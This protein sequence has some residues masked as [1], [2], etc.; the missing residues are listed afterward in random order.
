MGLVCAQQESTSGPIYVTSLSETG[1]RCSPADPDLDRHLF[2]RFRDWRQTKPFPEKLVTLQGLS[3]WEFSLTGFTPEAETAF[4]AAADIWAS[5]LSSP[6]TI[7]VDAE[8]VDLGDLGALGLGGPTLLFREF[9]GGVPQTFYAEAL[10]DALAGADLDPGNSDI[11]VSINSGFTGWYLGTDGNPPPDQFDLLS[12]VL[13]ELG[14]GLG[15]VDSFDVNTSGAG[16][17]GLDGRPLIYDHFVEDTSGRNLIDTA[18]YPNS[19]TT[20]GAAL[21]SIVLFN[22]AN[23]SGAVL[24][25]PSSFSGSSIVHLDDE[26]YPH[27]NPDA[28]MNPFLGNGQARH[29]LGPI[30]QGIFQDMG[31]AW[32]N[33]T[34]N[35]APFADAGPSQ[36]VDEGETV[37]LDSVG[38][39]DPDGDTLSVFWSQTAGPVVSFD[40]SVL[41]LSFQAPQ[42]DGTTLLTFQ[43]TLDDGA[44]SDTDSVNVTVVDL[45][46]QPPTINTFNV[47]NSVTEM[48][49]RFAN[50]SASD[51]DGD[52]L[53]YSWSFAADPTGQAHFFNATTAAYTKTAS[54]TLVVFGVGNPGANPPSPSLQGRQISVKVTVSDGNNTVVETRQ[55]VVS[56][57]NAKPVIILSTAGM[58]TMANPKVSPGALSLTAAD[59]FNPDGSIRFAWKLGSI[60]GGQACPGKVLV[61]FGK[62]TDKPSMPIPLVTAFPSDPMRVNFVYRVIDGMYVLEDSVV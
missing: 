2:A 36:Q 54:G 43:L 33:E 38:G 6:V 34:V 49:I 35:H 16:S 46:N 5:V 21:T 51:A 7:R 31:W 32:L 37:F 1:T 24:F 19:S 8:F 61:L 12:A 55:V 53:T 27:G 39:L 52:P 42:V 15:F 18:I 50:V 60:S 40:S 26:T 3:T 47:P 48:G 41:N 29:N 10:A 28:L 56:G 58:G 13:H 17:W 59:S 14:H 45:A 4:M 23:T 20:L 62:E 30:T 25:S 57:S 44:A 11:T 22:G 9:V